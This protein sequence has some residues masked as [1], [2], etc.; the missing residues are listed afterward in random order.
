M[1]RQDEFNLKYGI[2]PVAVD[3][4]TISGNDKIVPARARNNSVTSAK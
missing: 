4:A 3:A 1:K 2:H